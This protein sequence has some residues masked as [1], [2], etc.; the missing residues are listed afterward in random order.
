MGVDSNS[1]DGISV[2]LLRD[3]H[4]GYLQW[5]F[6]EPTR[7]RAPLRRSNRRLMATL[8]SAPWSAGASRPIGPDGFAD[9]PPRR[10]SRVRVLTRIQSLSRSHH[11]SRTEQFRRPP[12]RSSRRPSHH[13]LTTPHSL[14]SSLAILFPNPSQ[15]GHRS[16]T[17]MSI[18][19]LGIP[20]THPLTLR[21]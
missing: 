3:A 8:R 21:S 14:A 17:V 5:H 7:C 16:G 10:N 9:T 12:P 20:T 15:L 1:Q 11:T 18:P 2:L 13:F 6:P 19:P 4:P